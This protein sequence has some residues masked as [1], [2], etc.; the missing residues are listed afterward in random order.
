[1]PPRQRKT[2]RF[3]EEDEDV[4]VAPI[5]EEDRPAYDDDAIPS[6]APRQRAV[7]PPGQGKRD[8]E[9]AAALERE[10]A[11]AARPARAGTRVVEEEIE[12]VY[13]D[14]PDEERVYD[15]EEP[16]PL[17]PSATISV[18]LSQAFSHRDKNHIV[19]IGVEDSL[20]PIVDE[21]GEVVGIE[22][23][24]EAGERIQEYVLDR[25]DAMIA[26]T[27]ENIDLRLKAEAAAVRRQ[28]GIDT[29]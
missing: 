4:I 8:P 18:K 14:G 16:Y 25:I 15:D 23:A 12:D 26:R 17:T 29:P 27:R 20:F 10:R 1:M 24:E 21:T 19:I 7:R 28:R 3:R 13:E 22:S 11:V 6:A 5:P 2:N 9:L